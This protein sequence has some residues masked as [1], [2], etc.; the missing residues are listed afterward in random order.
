MAI[1]FLV[2]SKAST[3]PFLTLKIYN[4]LGELV[5]ELMV[6]EPVDKVQEMVVRW[7]GLTDHHLK[8]RNGRYLLR[9]IL[10]DTSGKK[11]YLK[12]IV[13]VK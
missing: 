5:R 13:L 6:Q 9:M 7:D 8:A 12:K 11:E 4:L 10:E 3:R 1:H 2:S